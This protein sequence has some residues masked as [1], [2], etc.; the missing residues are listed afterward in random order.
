MNRTIQSLERRI[1]K[2]KGELA[3]IGDLRPGSLSTQYNVC[4]KP[5][6]KCKATPPNPF[7]AAN[8]SFV[9]IWECSYDAER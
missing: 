9:R 5:K 1:A 6:C 3:Q 7:S 4:G 8:P 2:I